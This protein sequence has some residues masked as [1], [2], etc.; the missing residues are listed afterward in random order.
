MAATPA[1]SRSTGTAALVTACDTTLQQYASRGVF[2]GF[3]A[4]EGARG[5]RA[6]RFH[7]LTRRPITVSLNPSRKT[8]VFPQLFPA[9][10]STP[11]V[12][13]ALRETLRARQQPGVPPHRRIKR[14]QLD[15]TLEG[16]AGDLSLK[17]QMRGRDTAANISIVLTLINDFHLVLHECYPDYLVAHFGVS[18]E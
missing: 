6:Y 10:A 15:V 5:T 7:W 3:S 8:L 13:A 9:V 1:R 17:V 4:T 11:G 2:R 12:A 16:R 14:Q 18:D